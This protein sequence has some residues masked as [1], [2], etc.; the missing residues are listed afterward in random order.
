M[1]EKE[2]KECAFQIYMAMGD[3]ATRKGMIWAYCRAKLCIE[4]CYRAFG[5][6]VYH[7]RGFCGKGFE[8][9]AGVDGDEVSCWCDVEGGRK[10]SF[11]ESEADDWR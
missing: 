8:F 6:V 4:Q 7:V 11:G 2:A 3:D 1:T 5:G 10:W 9:V